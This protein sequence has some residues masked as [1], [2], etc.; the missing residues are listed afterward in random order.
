MQ[1][2]PV[3]VLVVI[4]LVASADSTADARVN[5]LLHCGG[6]HLP[7]GSGVPPEVPSL[8][9][10]PGKIIALPQGRDYLMRVPGVSQALLD[11]ADLAEVINY[12]MTEFNGDSLPRDFKRFTEDEVTEARVRVLADPAKRR[13]EL[14]GQ[15]EDRA[16]D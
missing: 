12:M 5:Y 6:C 3:L 16:R 2:L 8:L 15:Y 14:W 11:N 10:D 9:G 4:C 7:D 13:A 1:R